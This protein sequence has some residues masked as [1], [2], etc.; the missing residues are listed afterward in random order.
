MTTSGD[1][2]WNMIQT[3]A[4]K[5]EKKTPL[6]NAAKKKLK[7]QG[8]PQDISSIEEKTKELQEYVNQ[9]ASAQWEQKALVQVIYDVT[10]KSCGHKYNQHELH[11]TEKALIH[12]RNKRTG[13]EKITRIALRDVKPN[14]PRVSRILP[15]ES[16]TCPEC[17]D[18]ETPIQ[19]FEDQLQIPLSFKW[20]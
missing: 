15:A 7:K 5:K 11:L 4:F 9:M 1:D 6:S 19:M 3:G 8:K 20:N 12:L 17:F 10:C 13:A 14:L 16:I 2:L 18:P